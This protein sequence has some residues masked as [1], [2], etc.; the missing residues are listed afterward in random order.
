[1]CSPII[2]Q[3]N[4]VFSLL[5]EEIKNI[6]FNSDLEMKGCHFIGTRNIFNPNKNNWRIAYLQ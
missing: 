1:M 6:I 3:K 2:W 5:S 4:Y